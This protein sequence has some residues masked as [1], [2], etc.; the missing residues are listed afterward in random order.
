VANRDAILAFADELL[1]AASFDDYGPNG[2]QVPGSAEVTVVATGVSAHRELFELAEREGA[3][4]V[5][6]HHGILWGGAPPAVTPQLK[7]RLEVLFRS[8][9]SLAA[10]HL[11]LDAHPVIGN[12]AL[13]CEALGLTRGELFASV[14]GR[15]IGFVGRTEEGLAADDLV[16]RV[17]RATEREPLVVGRGPETVKAVGIVTG[18]GSSALEDAAA[19]GL[20]A[21]V[22]GEPAERATAD[23]R[24][25]G[26]HFVA[27]GHHA[28][29][30]FGIRRLGDMVAERFG[31]EHRFLDVPN[32]I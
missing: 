11:P 2:L 23:A 14:R 6:A 13:L 26:M 5:L 19:L 17:R 10:Y 18:A 30:T 8:D 22:T 32:P 12:N 16:D 31:V 1:D 21:F 25:A 20:D 29:E 3:Q 24:E 15:P 9:M 7:A 27:A 28:T 4:L